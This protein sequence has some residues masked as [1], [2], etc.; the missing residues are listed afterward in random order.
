[1]SFINNF[2]E[3]IWGSKYQYKNETFEEFCDRIAYTIFSGEEKKA[4]QLKESIMGFRT[5]FGG[6]TN[7][8]IGIEE[9]GLTL[10]NCFIEA[11]SKSPDS[12]EGI[13]DM[14]TKYALTLKT[15]GGVGF[16]ANFLR[17][18]KTLIRKIGVTTPG[19]IKFLELFDKVSEIITSGSVS[20]EDSYQ[21]VPSKKSIRKGATMVTM[22]VNHP[23][24]EEFITAKSVPNRLTKMNM[25]VLITDAFMY[26][27]ENDMDW[28]LWFP[29][30]NFEKY[31]EEWDGDFEKWAEKGYPVSVYRTVKANYLW[32][33]IME[34]SYN[35]SE[36]GILFI[37]NIRRMDNLSYLNCTANCCNPC[38]TGD[39][40]LHTSNGMERIYDLYKHEQ[41]NDVYVDN[42]QIDDTL[43][44]SLL[45]ATPISKTGVNEKVFKITTVAGY[46]IKT[47]DYHEFNT[48]DGVKKLKDLKIND[49]LQL[50]SGECGFGQ[51]GDLAFGRLLGLVTGDGTIS[52][53][54]QANGY[55]GNRV[56]IRLW[57][58]D[59]SLADELVTTTNTLIKVYGGIYSDK[60]VKSIYIK[61][62]D[63]YEIKSG[64][65]YRIFD[66]FNLLC[67]K[68]GVPDFIFK[69][70]RE[71]V[72]GYLQGL[73]QADGT[74]NV[75]TRAGCSVRLNS[76]MPSLI[77]DV[78]ILLSNF[79][80]KSNIYLRREAAYRDL[81]DGNGGLKKY[82]CKD[83]YELILFSGSRDGFMN[84]I[85]FMLP[86][87]NDKF[88]S[89]RQGK[90]IRK[91]IFE[92][93]I[94]SIEF[95]GKEDVYCLTQEDHNSVICNGFS[96]RQCAEIPSNT[97]IVEY[98]GETYELGDVCN[99]GSLVLP[100]Y[101]DMETGKFNYDSFKDDIDIMI[102]AL[103]N[104]NDI[105][106][107]PLD[108]YE[109][110]AKM[111][112]KIGL[113]FTGLGSLFM[114]MGVKYGS[115]KS[116]EIIDEILSIFMNEAYRKS[117]L[118]A[119]EKGP[120]LLY[121]S[122]LL[123]GGYVANSGV[124][125]EDVLNLIKKYGL[126]NSAITAI[127]PT[128]TLSILAGNVSSGLE[129]VFSTEYYRWNRIGHKKVDFKYPIVH[130]GEW[131]ETD[132]LKEETVA[133]EIILISTD[134]EYRVDKGQG[135]CKR[136]LI[137]DYGYLKALEYGKT[138][139]TTAM[140]L[141]VQEHFNVLKAVTSKIDQ[142]SSK[143]VSLDT[144]I[145][146]NKGLLKI[147]DI[148]NNRKYDTFQEVKDLNV[149]TNSSNKSV[150]SFYY[151]GT[152]EGKKIITKIG[153]ELS[154]SNN[155]KIKVLNKDHQLVWKSMDTVLYDDII[156]IQLNKDISN[157]NDIE[158][159]IGAIFIKPANCKKITI[160]LQLTE[161]LLW[162]LGCV[163]ADG[164]I[165]SIG[166]HLTQVGGDVLNK[167]IKICES[168]FN[169]KPTITKDKRRENLF[170]VSINSKVL[171]RWMDYIGFSKNNISE[172]VFC[173]TPSFK[174]VFIEGITL[175][176]CV[177]DKH[178]CLKTDQYE[179][180]IKD[181]QLL[182]TAVGIPTYISTKFNKEYEKYYYDLN[183]STFHVSK[184]SHFTFPEAHKQ[185]N[186][187]KLVNAKKYSSGNCCSSYHIRLP[188]NS[189]FLEKIKSIEKKTSSSTP[190]YNIF[191]GIHADA[192]KYNSLTFSQLLTV[193]TFIGTVPKLFT[194]SNI[195]FTSIKEIENIQIETSDIEVEDEHSYIANGF[196]SH[197][198]INL[199]S[200]IPFDDFKAL[201]GEIH[202]QGIKG[203]TTYRAGTSIAVLETKKDR[204]KKKIEKQQEEFLD[205]FKGHENG[206][207]M[208]DVVK[209]PEEFPS[210]SYILRMQNRKWYVSV[211]FKNREMTK[212]FCIFVNTNSPSATPITMSAIDRLVDLVKLK[213]LGGCKLAE[214]EKK[215]ANQKNSVK[216]ARMLGF[217]LRHNVKIID[218]IKALDKVEDAHPGTFVFRIKKFLG[219]F[220]TESVDLGII[221][222]ECGSSDVILQEGCSICKSCGSSLC[223]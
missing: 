48:S 33:L 91:Q 67:T 202:H 138:E 128:G 164:H 146:T 32:N 184:M 80:F 118:L 170:R 121:D 177:S 78:Q 6:R 159:I 9:E 172:L 150:K 23:D 122:K 57:G 171:Y 119:K 82:W 151:N 60:T 209:L 176:G 108:M 213:G 189:D 21:G 143:C 63:M 40:L 14:A 191:H 107:Y 186:L 124:L 5:L 219:Q 27:V 12:L 65:L 153:T 149:S 160:P 69:G 13:M 123:E 105:S 24:I 53:C 196:I 147:K 194:K 25:S 73:F 34:N 30:I 163:Y 15:E 92:D 158:E 17:P 56:H 137:Q 201:Y 47:T 222:P 165:N 4:E 7:S 39:M 93:K 76:S 51:N 206:N 20:K 214:V 134:G 148:S 125:D 81:P 10:F 161:D 111:K 173:S 101:Y 130:S 131:F 156:P 3:E 102:E 113:G 38:F 54:T 55:S 18:A 144:R 79:G 95:V 83:N 84:E 35:R 28:D 8:N 195:L 75:S 200:N 1:M 193:Y 16:C 99:L 207:I 169:R 204:K 89:W 41:S 115:S 157:R 220:V 133:D 216:I 223:S 46:E 175:D 154:G 26:S 127:A 98:K 199:P 86:Y 36:P 162:W 112:R 205:A 203:C 185:S 210:K 62:K 211:G 97:G 87:K 183:V 145:N 109:N 88:F 85:G 19:S 72:K 155:H 50:C 218:I 71:F 110:S 103:D 167:Y 192:K 140:E 45:P 37:D 152:V 116:V 64:V 68:S 104:V 129:P 135:L 52:K 44:T 221:C 132:Y 114:M 139:Y 217:C 58:K 174:K 168:L 29:D 190:L 77:K 141:S 166:V 180:I 106:G 120:F 43:G 181:L 94:K 117:A 187:I 136:E 188:I 126:R 90:S 31:D 11:V 182:C 2:Q 208:Y 142:S 179:N 215:F 42:R 70:N 22:N 66:K 74:V 96:T 198:T 197:N 178:I 61:N 212:P 49:K 59:K 100:Y